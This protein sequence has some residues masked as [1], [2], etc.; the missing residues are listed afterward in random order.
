MHCSK[1][2]SCCLVSDS[3]SVSIVNRYEWSSSAKICF[4]ARSLVRLTLILYRC[5]GMSSYSCSTFSTWS[6]RTWP[7]APQTIAAWSSSMR[8][9]VAPHLSHSRLPWSC[10]FFGVSSHIPSER[11]SRPSANAGSSCL[12]IRL[13]WFWCAM[14]AVRVYDGSS[15]ESAPRSIESWTDRPSRLNS[16]SFSTQKSEDIIIK[17]P[18]DE[19]IAATN[20]RTRNTSKRTIASKGRRSTRKIAASSWR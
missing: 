6:C 2:A 18:S 17:W 15:G 1:A 7:H 5:Y 16:F 9:A 10:F 13:C 11:R 14:L 19:I 12:S 3:N 8:K 20:N 4:G